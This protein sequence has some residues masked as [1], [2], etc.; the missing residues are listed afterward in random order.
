CSAFI[1][2]LF[3]CLGASDSYS[4][5]YPADGGCGFCAHTTLAGRSG[6]PHAVE[7]RRRTGG[8]YGRFSAGGPPAG[9]RISIRPWPSPRLSDGVV[10]LHGKRCLARWAA[11]WVPADVLQ[12]GATGG[13]HG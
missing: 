11:F 7:R 3:E 13:H 8:R 9:H 6:D 10:V 5:R 2:H 4:D 1:G 12:D